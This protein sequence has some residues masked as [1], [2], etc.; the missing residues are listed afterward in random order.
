MSVAQR[1]SVEQT[2]NGRRLAPPPL[3]EIADRLQVNVDEPVP[4]VLNRAL[5]TRVLLLQ[6][7]GVDG[8]AWPAQWLAATPESDVGFGIGLAFEGIDARFAGSG[9]LERL[10]DC[11]LWICSAAVALRDARTR[12]LARHVLRAGGSVAEACRL[13]QGCGMRLAPLDLDSEVPLAFASA[14]STVAVP[15]ALHP[16]LELLD[17][18][19]LLPEAL[20]FQGRIA[21]LVQIASEA[22]WQVE[23]QQD[24]H[25]ALRSGIALYTELSRRVDQAYACD[26]LSV[27]IGA[28]RGRNT[29]D[30]RLRNMPNDR[31][32]LLLLV[33]V[34]RLGSR[35]RAFTLREICRELGAVATG[36]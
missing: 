22:V 25:A 24:R 23:A 26:T 3:P 7:D 6:H 17:V 34:A 18:L 27:L 1:G 4:G 8:A 33:A 20:R 36:T 12:E 2:G 35:A 31:L 13:E 15:W 30:N 11:Q 14:A 21:L 9:R 28:V 10:D 29:L 19:N 16:A 5:R 32:G